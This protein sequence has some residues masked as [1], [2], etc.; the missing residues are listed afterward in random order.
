MQLFFWQQIDDEI[1]R[2]MT[3]ILFRWIERSELQL[4][5]EIDRSEIIH[6]GYEMRGRRL[7]AM[8]VEWNV[9]NF[10]TKSEGEH[11]IA[12]QVRFCNSHME[13]GACCRGAFEDGR[14]VGIGILTPNI[15]PGMAQ[16]AYLH[17]SRIYRRKGIATSIVDD[18]ISWAR[19]NEQSQVYVSATPSGSAVGFYSRFGFNP[20]DEPIPELFEIEPED[21]H[22]IKDLSKE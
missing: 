8:D 5:A 21:I 19:E 9:P 4:I 13:R 6:V 14:L 18:L 16:L 17:V 1:N 20:I 22:M 7:T 12:E 3:N 15:R 10:T 2:L 11:S